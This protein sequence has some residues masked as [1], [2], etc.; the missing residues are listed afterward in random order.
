MNRIWVVVGVLAVIVGVVFFFQGVGALK[1]SS[2][3]GSSFWMWVGL[4]LI[5]AGGVAVFRG[6]RAGRRRAPS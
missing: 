2:M 6:A 4:I 1:G 5:I 3:T